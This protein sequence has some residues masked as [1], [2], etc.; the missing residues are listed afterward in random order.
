M[1]NMK[2][3]LLNSKENQNNFVYIV[4]HSDF[5]WREYLQ[6]RVDKQRYLVKDVIDKV[7]AGS[8]LSFV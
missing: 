5:T 3:F 1:F 7:A 2:I 4:F 8:L 6:E